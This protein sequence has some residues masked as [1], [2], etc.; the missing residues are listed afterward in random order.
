MA[1][2]ERQTDYVFDRIYMFSTEASPGDMGPSP[3][4]PKPK[5][6][7]KPYA[8]VAINSY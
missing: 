1:V 8:G 4:Q 3:T 7:P 2:V 6:K 5:P